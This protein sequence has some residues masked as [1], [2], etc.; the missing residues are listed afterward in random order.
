MAERR[1]ASSRLGYRIAAASGVLL[2]ISGIA[3]NATGARNEKPRII[4]EG[5]ARIALS[6]TQLAELRIPNATGQ[7]GSLLNIREPMKYGQYVWDERGVPAGPIS[8][9]IDL[10]AQMISV[11]RSGHEIGSAVILYG[12]DEKPTPTG[13]FQV[14]GKL[15]DHRSSLYDAAMPYTLRL[16]SDG[17]AIHGSDVRRGA[18]THGCVG[19]PTAFAGLVFEQVKR[20]DP[21]LII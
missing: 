16:T 14:I 17:I 21:A 18:A 9:R 2:C 1:R 3:G 4:N 6:R 15:K 13:H 19:V 8:I 20:G 7:A 12:A 11:V 5:A 10:A